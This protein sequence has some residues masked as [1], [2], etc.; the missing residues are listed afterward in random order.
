MSR[1]HKGKS[2]QYQRKISVREGRKFDRLIFAISKA[3][4]DQKY[5]EQDSKF[6]DR[7]FIRRWKVK[8]YKFLEDDHQI[9]LGSY[10]KF[11]DE[12]ITKVCLEQFSSEHI[13]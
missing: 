5:A 1:V 6:L 8:L 7:A 10:E 3:L 12:Y 4:H 13:V 11:S 9:S 2:E